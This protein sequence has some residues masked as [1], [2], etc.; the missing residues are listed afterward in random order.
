[1]FLESVIG[2]GYAALDAIFH[3]KAH[4]EGA[5]V[6]PRFQKSIQTLVS[7]ERALKDESIGIPWCILAQLLSVKKVSINFCYT[8]S[9]DLCTQ[10]WSLA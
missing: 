3:F 2:I 10:S 4:L 8:S 9:S 5:C 7:F 1:M 6:E